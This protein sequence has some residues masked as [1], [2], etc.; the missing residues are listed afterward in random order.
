MIISFS[1][2]MASGKD[3]NAVELKKELAKKGYSSKIV[4]FGELLREELTNIINEIKNTDEYLSKKYNV[5]VS[6]IQELK[7]KVDINCDLYKKTET[8]REL[9]QWWGTEVRRKQNRN[10]WSDLAKEKYLKLLK[11]YDYL[12]VT[13]ARFLNELE[14]LE[15]LF[16]Y[17]VCLLVGEKEQLK[18][19]KER[20][21]LVP[22]REQ[23]NHKSEKEFM[24]YFDDFDYVV[25]TEQMKPEEVS[26]TIIDEITKTYSKE[27]I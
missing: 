16:A 23:L 26:K 22:T 13:D 11:E 1:G 9:L 2:K 8:S 3:T 12:L 10:Y 7:N 27:G 21:N 14:M 18:R 20:D 15:S 19:I 6:I 17:R 25:D 5:D 4:S 24:A